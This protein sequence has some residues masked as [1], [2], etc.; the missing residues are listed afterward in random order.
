MILFDIIA[1]LL[2]IIFVILVMVKKSILA[3]KG[4]KYYY[5]NRILIYSTLI[6]FIVYV[7]KLWDAMIKGC[8]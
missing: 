4:H 6:V 7:V 8:L 5:I 1:L 3:D 2:I